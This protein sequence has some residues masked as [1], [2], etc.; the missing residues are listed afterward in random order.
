[1]GEKKKIRKAV[2]SL[3][4]R[5]REHEQK[6]KS[7]MGEKRWDLT[8]YY[9]KEIERLKAQKRKKESRL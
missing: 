4:K 6:M 5:I 1:M 2:K 8:R 9:P 3:E 7:A